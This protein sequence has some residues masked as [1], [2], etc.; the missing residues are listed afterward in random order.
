MPETR[1]RFPADTSLEVQTLLNNKKLNGELYGMF[2][3]LAQSPFDR[4]GK[5]GETYV[6]KKD[7]PSQAEI[8]KKLEIRSPKTLRNHLSQ[9]INAGYLIED[10]NNKRYILPELEDMYLMI[11]LATTQYLWDNCREHVFKLYVYLGQRYK[12][13]QVLNRG[14]Y[15]FTLNELGEHLGIGVKNHSEVY[16]VIN[17]ALALLQDVGLIDFEE[18]YI[19]KVPYKRLKDFSFYT[20]GVKMD[21]Q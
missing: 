7:L 20:R 5:K 15:D 17:N 6:N 10:E 9:L 3:A 16:R 14:Y 13:S 1:R 19:N 11:P 12:Y 18:V 8:C 21:S 2:Q 4:T